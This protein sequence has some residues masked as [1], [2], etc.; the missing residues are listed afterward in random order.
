L[1]VL[2]AYHSAMVDART[3]DLSTVLDDEFSLVHIT[4]YVQ[5][6]AEW[7]GV[8]RSRE[9]ECRASTSTKTWYR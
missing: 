8:I 1:Q 5:P 9:F 7:F 2:R 3:D 6:R 4:G